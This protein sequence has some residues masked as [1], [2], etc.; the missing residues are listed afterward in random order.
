M[1]DPRTHVELVEKVSPPP[2][3]GPVG[4]RFIGVTVGLMNDILSEG[5]AAAASAQW[6]VSF[7]PGGVNDRPEGGLDFIGQASGL[8]RYDAETPAEYL[9][10]LLNR[11]TLWTQGPKLTLASELASAGFVVGGGFGPGTGDWSFDGVD[12]YVYIGD[13]ALLSPTATTPFSVSGWYTGTDLNGPIF[14]KMQMSPFAR[15]WTLHVTSGK[16]YGGLFNTDSPDTGIQGL[17]TIVC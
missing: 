8:P 5:A 15:G 4:S 16:L 11:W 12:D 14:S 3:S 13:V 6:L 2:W 10:R 9:D 17:G 1:A 7:R